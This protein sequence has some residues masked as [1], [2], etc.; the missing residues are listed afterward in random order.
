MHD[1]KRDKNPQPLGNLP[2]TSSIEATIRRDQPVDAIR[3][4]NVCHPFPTS[5]LQPVWAQLLP[6]E[7]EMFP[8]GL[9]IA[10]LT[11]QRV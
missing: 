3:L 8:L 4:S 9:G 2:S 6:A 11:Q 1:D 7:E 10:C 5:K